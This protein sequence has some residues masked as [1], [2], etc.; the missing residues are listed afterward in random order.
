M[1]GKLLHTLAAA[2]AAAA[3]AAAA[4]AASMRLPLSLLDNMH[5]ATAM[6]CSHAQRSL[7]QRIL[8]VPVRPDCAWG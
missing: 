4:P 8:S 1:R 3:A 6:Y 5:V 2:S 7:S